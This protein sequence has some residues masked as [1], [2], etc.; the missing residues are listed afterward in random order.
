VNQQPISST[1]NLVLASTPE[2]GADSWERE[3]VTILIATAVLYAILAWVALPSLSF[4]TIGLGEEASIS[5]LRQMSFG[6]ALAHT[7]AT[8]WR[9]GESVM[10]WLIAHSPSLVPWRMAMLA[11]LLLTTAYLQYDC[12]VRSRS[13]LDGFGAAVAFSLNPTT[14]SVVCWFSAAN[15]S[16]CALGLLGYV[17][18]ARRA[19]ET[20][21]SPVADAVCAALALTFALAFYELALFAPLIVLAYQYL[22]APRPQRS[23]KLYL[24][25]GSALCVLAYLILQV[26]L[27]DLPRFWADAAPLD[28]LAS[29]MR[30][31]MWNFYLWFNPF[32]T[33]GVFIPDQVAGHAL[34]NLS[35]FLLV[36]GGLWVSWYFRKRDPLT[37][38]S[39][40]WF[41]V[42]LAPVGTVFHFEGSPVAEQHLYIPVLG[43]ALGGV[44]LFTRFCE[45]LLL[46]IRNKPARVVF[47]LTFSVFLLWSLAPLVAECKRTVEHWGDSRELYLTTLQNYPASTGA[48][49]HLT[50][51]LSARP[52]P[53]TAAADPDKPEWTQVVDAFLLCPR[54][55]PAR[56]LLAEGRTLMQEERY[57]AASSA[58]A[59]A[60]ATSG[61][62]REQFDAGK[63]LVQALSHTSL[64]G[65]TP[66]LLQRLRQDHPEVSPE[67]EG[68]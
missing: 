56:Q 29:S 47:E 41:L 60:Y 34:E 24:Y 18:F 57:M 27:A 49:D 53:L 50:E 33:F 63:G 6:D 42:F 37:A 65:R 13:H 36:A 39:G 3:R 44:R 4:Q 59:R 1:E 26:E 23:A 35:G 45:G 51:V 2:S 61:S 48:L 28:L 31:V 54:P 19:L 21:D 68:L 32:E 11:I 38:L 40:I 25:G 15:I 52:V 46:R 16:L 9:P 58:L 64:R 17:A 62:A 30:Y 55:Q 22:L 66:A 14:L 5:A 7:S 20:D 8:W 43:V 12:T 10:L 67:L